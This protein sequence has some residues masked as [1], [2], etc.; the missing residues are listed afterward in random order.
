MIKQKVSQGQKRKNSSS[1]GSSDEEEAA[2][3]LEGET[4]FSPEKLQEEACWN[5]GTPQGGKE[6][7]RTGP[8]KGGEQVEKPLE[9]GRGPIC[10]TW[11][12]ENP[13]A[14]TGT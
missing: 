2:P 6:G 13:L 7:L 4:E 12:W 3:D 8:V 5:L 1:R 9:L 14:R 11:M 10:S